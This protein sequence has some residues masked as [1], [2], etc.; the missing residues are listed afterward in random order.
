MT[1]NQ[2]RALLT[3]IFLD[4][5]DARDG[6][7]AKTYKALFASAVELAGV[8]APGEVSEGR[9]KTILGRAHRVAIATGIHGSPLLPA[10]AIVGVLRK[11]IEVGSRR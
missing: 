5:Q 9:A 11:A 6:Y 3:I 2:A 1:F 7:S 10:Q 4:R 8:A